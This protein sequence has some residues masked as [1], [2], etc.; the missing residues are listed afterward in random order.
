EAAPLALRRRAEGSVAAA[1]LLPRV[2]GELP[3]DREGRRRRRREARRRRRAREHCPRAGVRHA[4]E[5]RSR[6]RGARPLTSHATRS[7]P[8]DPVTTTTTLAMGTS[9]TL[10]MGMGDPTAAGGLD[11]NVWNLIQQGALS[12]YPLL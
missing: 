7:V 3:G 12:T 9:T 1:R 4:M 11:L 2:A 10:A 5:E 6:P 8:M